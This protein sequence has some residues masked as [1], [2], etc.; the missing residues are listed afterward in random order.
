MTVL[1]A[2]L[3]LF[4]SSP[5]AEAADLEFLVPW[6]NYP[7]WWMGG[8]IYDWTE[9]GDANAQVPV[10]AVINPN[11]GPG[12]PPN[13]DYVL[14]LQDLRDRGVRMLGYVAT[15]WGSRSV[16]NVSLD[17]ATYQSSYVSHG[18]TG[19]F[20]DEA[21]TSAALV[22]HY[23]SLFALGGALSPVVLNPGT[24]PNAS[25]FDANVSDIVVAFEGDA[26]TWLGTPPF[27]QGVP[28]HKTSVMIYGA[29]GVQ[30]MQHAIDL[31]VARGVTYVYVTHDALQPNPWDE[32]PT[33]W[34]EEVDYVQRWNDGPQGVECTP[35]SPGAMATCTLG[36][37]PRGT[38]VHFVAG[39]PGTTCPP[40]LSDC[41]DIRAPAYLGADR[42]DLSGE[43]QV[44][45]RV[46]ASV[47]SG[48]TV[49]VQAA[50]MG[51]TGSVWP[52]FETT[53]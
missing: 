37:V 46:P 53:L 35:L 32:L 11:N 38:E 10:T 33:F 1:F 47:P 43:A 39:L 9:L 42:S 5:E 14:G 20:Y 52:A 8:G 18:V 26:P 48:T 3:A 24:V 41:V 49:R 16:L 13:S 2:V 17:V 31:A 29:S 25:Y 44:R 4:A 40:F 45:F 34:Q 51:P 15:G 28:A 50:T 21:A 6:Y 22:P 23:A 27:P 7:V 30:E 12:G 36:P 19:L